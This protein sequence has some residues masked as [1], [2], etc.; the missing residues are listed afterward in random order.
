MPYISENGQTRFVTQAEFEAF[1]EANGIP[2]PPPRR[3][4]STNS[5]T[6][7]A[8]GTV[9]DLSSPNNGLTSQE[10][11]QLAYK[12]QAQVSSELTSVS[13]TLAQNKAGKGSLSPE[14][15]AK[16]EARRD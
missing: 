11:R 14:E 13:V 8:G 5:T 2:G 12:Q 3:G 7:P 4:R 1:N 10:Q 16:L 9:T 15:V 6:A